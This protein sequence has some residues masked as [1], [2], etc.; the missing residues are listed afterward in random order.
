MIEYSMNLPVMLEY[1]N[2]FII[3]EF[4]LRVYLTMSQQVDK[5][6]RT[7]MIYTATIVIIYIIVTITTSQIYCA[8]NEDV[9]KTSTYKKVSDI[10]M[11]G[12]V[13]VINPIIVGIVLKQLKSRINT[14]GT[15]LTIFIKIALLGCLF[16][17]A[18]C[19]RILLVVKQDY[20]KKTDPWKYN[21]AFIAY[22]L[23]GEVACQ[24]LLIY[25]IIVYT[26][27]LRVKHL[28]KSPS[29]SPDNHYRS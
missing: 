8:Q 10:T 26:H 17:L 25:G 18:C 20:W 6:R 27:K 16:E 15:I 21:L 12:I 2:I 3:H 23:V 7:L 24:I 29:S 14:R 11:A 5:Y 9:T 13:I 1:I 28:K 4:L 19:L 22:I